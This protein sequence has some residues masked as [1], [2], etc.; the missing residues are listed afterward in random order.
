MTQDQLREQVEQEINNAAAGTNRADLPKNMGILIPSLDLQAAVNR[1]MELIESY[2]LQAR[3]SEAKLA[4]NVIEGFTYLLGKND[5]IDIKQG[6]L[7]DLTL[8]Q[9]NRLDRLQG[10]PLTKI[11]A[12]DHD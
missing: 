8:V 5:Y 4:Q 6:A 3:V 2:V 1:T 12:Y 10:K 9:Q 11:E 7:E